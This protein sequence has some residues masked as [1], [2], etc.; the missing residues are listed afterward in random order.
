MA[1]AGASA[2]LINKKFHRWNFGILAM[3]RE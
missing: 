2:A 3:P 1:R